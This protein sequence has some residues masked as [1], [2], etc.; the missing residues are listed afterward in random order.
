MTLANG[1]KVP[2][3]TARLALIVDEACAGLDGVD[4]APVIA[5]THRNIYD[6][7][8]QDELALASVMAARTLVEQEPNYAYVSARLLLD[9]L[10]TEVLSY[11]HGVPTNASQAEMASALR[12]IFP[13]L[14]QDRHQGRTARSRSRPL[15]PQARSPR[16]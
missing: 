2:L 12:R 10:R 9:K 6:G 16:R 14:Y 8:S 3:D 15:R 11:V 4:A 5:E 7:I 1:A 13:G